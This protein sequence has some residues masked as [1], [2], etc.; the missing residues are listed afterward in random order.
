ML[1]LWVLLLLLLFLLSSPG[2]DVLCPIS[3]GGLNDSPAVGEASERFNNPPLLYWGTELKFEA[4]TW[5][6]RDGFSLKWFRM[7]WAVGGTLLQ[8]CHGNLPQFIQNPI[9]SKPAFN[10][11]SVQLTSPERVSLGVRV[12]FLSGPQPFLGSAALG[13]SF[14]S[15]AESVP[16]GESRLL[17]RSLHSKKDPKAKGFLS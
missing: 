7:G 14:N 17:Q 6:H 8:R 5:F 13:A 9:N 12:P 3:G 16:F 11:A 10:H 4:P 2:V 15:L 1:Q